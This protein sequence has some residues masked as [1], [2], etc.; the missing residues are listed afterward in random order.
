MHPKYFLSTSNIVD[1]A[2][3]WCHLICEHTVNSQNTCLAGE[4]FGY[5]GNVT[6]LLLLFLVLHDEPGCGITDRLTHT[7]PL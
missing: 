1:I 6:V 3:P 7:H 5:A 2:E 4:V